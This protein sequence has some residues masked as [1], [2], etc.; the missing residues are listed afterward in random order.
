MTLLDGLTAGGSQGI[1]MHARL[2]GGRGSISLFGC[3]N[4]A[5]LIQFHVIFPIFAATSLHSSLME[6][7]QQFRGDC[8]PRS[9]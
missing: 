2:V 7:E 3:I 9:P 1:H 8:G 6:D 4:T 5:V